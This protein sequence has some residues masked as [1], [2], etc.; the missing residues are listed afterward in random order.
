MTVTL[1]D[2]AAPDG[3]PIV[4]GRPIPRLDHL[5]EH[6]WKS[7]NAGKLLIQKCPECEHF[8]FYPRAL[9]TQCGAT[10]EWF[11][12]AG[13]GTVYT[14]TVIRQNGAKPFSAILPY[15]VAMIELAE[16]PKIMGN[17]THCDPDVVCIG[18]EVSFY[19]VS[20]T[21]EIGIPFWRLIETVGQH[22]H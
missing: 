11:E 3:S 5:S 12:T 10:P 4:E 1:T 6:F 16:G 19:P 9:C 17:V 18:M 15:V 21:E 2:D 7:V 14:Y 20:M 8:Q 22:G 13:R